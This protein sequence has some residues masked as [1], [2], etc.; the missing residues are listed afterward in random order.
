M[1]VTITRS[2]RTLTTAL[3]TMF[4]LFLFITPALAGGNYYVN[5]TTGNDANTCTSAD[6]PCL[7]MLAAK[8]KIVA[9]AKPQNTTLYLAGTI[10]ETISF[11]DADVTA[12]V[13]LNGLRI[14]ATDTSAPP[15]IN[16][17]GATVALAVTDINNITIDNLIVEDAYIGISV[18]GNTVNNVQSVTLRNNTIQSAPSDDAT[19]HYPITVSNAKGVVI[20]NNTIADSTIA[21]TD[22]TSSYFYGIYVNA[23]SDVKVRNNT[24]RDITISNTATAASGHY[25]YI[26]GIYT[27]YSSDVTLRGNTVRD[28]TVEEITNQ[29]SLYMSSYVYGFYLYGNVDITVRNNRVTAL[30]VTNSLTGVNNVSYSYLYGMLIQDNLREAD[31]NNLVKKNTI[32]D[33]SIISGADIVY[34]TITG[35]T[36]TSNDALLATGNTL[37]N[38]TIT[39]TTTVESG[40]VRG[41]I[42][43]LDGPSY[44]LSNDVRNNT[45]SG[46]AINTAYS[47][48]NSESSHNIFGVY[49]LNATSSTYQNNTFKNFSTT[50]TTNNANTYYDYG[51]VYGM[52]LLY[53][54]NNL[55]RN[56]TIRNFTTT[57]NNAGEDGLAYF[58]QYG[59]A[60]LRVNTNVVQ[61]NTI[62][63]LDTSITL[64]DAT[65]QSSAAMYQYGIWHN[66]G[67][68]TQ[69]LANTIRGNTSTLTE[70]GDNSLGYYYYGIVASQAPNSVI[71]NNAQYNHTITGNGANFAVYGHS[72][73]G[74]EGSTLQSNVFRDISTTATD[75]I[76]STY[77]YYA[78][79]TNGQFFLDA[80]VMRDIVNNASIS[81][82]IYGL[83]L[84]T[85]SSETFVMNNILL[86]SADYETQGAT[87]YGINL[88]RTA[89]NGAQII[90]NT[91]AAWNRPISLGGGKNLHIK[92]NIFE[93]VGANS[94]AMEVARNYVDN[95]TLDS[96]YNLFYNSTAG[97]QLIYDIDAAAKIHF[98][99]W[100]NKGGSYGYD[101]KS[102]KGNPKLNAKGYLKTGSKAI[103]NGTDN[104]GVSK[105][106]AAYALLAVDIQSDPRPYKTSKVDIG[107]D[108]YEK[109]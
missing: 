36:L 83:Y 29:D 103:N 7:T 84:N 50:T 64:S 40:Y 79:D 1:E 92:N 13:V 96:N 76:A 17:G 85:D 56:N 81:G 80:N 99:D 95:D 70:S 94:Y 74:M 65:G 88:P 71:R 69:L 86:G 35:S 75:G 100:T 25:G 3:T 67:S 15:T 62:R 78:Y 20:K 14:T 23:S 89:S 6:S 41:T 48:A 5:G 11:D 45:F 46:Y 22:S 109:K 47:A 4:G 66:I 72:V 19:T 32:Q 26:N 2:S 82:T 8:S 101:L 52:Y 43:G 77:G 63:N 21:L 93:A 38:F 30:T 106:G 73:N 107:A 59:I 34:G 102:K 10:A 37:S 54:G 24:V 108:E 27:S 61:D 18:S 58:Y 87:N 98:G 55:V 53:G 97:G 12:P 9:Q 44:A 68:A 57:Y 39:P 33:L 51:S 60:M 16:G 28:I 91:V 105:K 104:Y 42:Y 31:G 90:N 49:S